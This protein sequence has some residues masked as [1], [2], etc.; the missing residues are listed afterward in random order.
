M[1]KEQIP[2]VLRKRPK[3]EYNGN[4]YSLKEFVLYLDE[5]EHKPKY[6]AILLDPNGNTTVRASIDNVKII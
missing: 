4:E 6:S 3:L 5:K 1:Q 2:D